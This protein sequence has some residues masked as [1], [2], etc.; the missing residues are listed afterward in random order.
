MKIF[1]LGAILLF[2]VMS[3]TTNSKIDSEIDKKMSETL[4]DYSS[5][6][7]METKITDTIYVGAI[8]RSEIN[9][10]VNLRHPSVTKMAKFRKLENSKEVISYIVSHKYRAKN[11]LGAL[12]IYEEVFVFDKN[13]KLFG[14]SQKVF[15]DITLSIQLFYKEYIN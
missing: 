6:E 3:C 9:D 2:S 5:Y 11:G 8:A 7:P 4:K 13:L 15:D 1:L 10:P 12:D 14:K